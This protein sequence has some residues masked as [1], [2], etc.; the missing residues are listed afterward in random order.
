MNKFGFLIVVV[1]FVAITFAVAVGLKYFHAAVLFSVVAAVLAPVAI[2][3][4]PESN[5]ATGMLVGLA[6]FA[7]YPFRK[8]F[9]IDSLI[10]YMLVT[11]ACLAVLWLI[12]F[13]WKRSWK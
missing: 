3:K 7:S 6:V 8:Y 2:H 12:G 13:G 5:I 9:H 10:A 1:I 4:I 11:L